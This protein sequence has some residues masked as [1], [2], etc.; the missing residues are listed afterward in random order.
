MCNSSCLHISLEVMFFREIQL[1]FLK[2]KLFWHK[3]MRWISYN[4][5]VG[6]AQ[7][8]NTDL[9]TFSLVRAY[10][11]L[12]QYFEFADGRWTLKIRTRYSLMD[13]LAECKVVDFLNKVV[14]SAVADD[15]LFCIS[16]RRYKLRHRHRSLHTYA[17]PPLHAKL[18]KSN[19]YMTY[20]V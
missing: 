20:R 16:K 18:V 13:E 17:K 19:K 12:K 5:L 9:L 2:T 7:E 11:L 8:N 3:I 6:V 14:I 15:T 10:A 1:D 4:I